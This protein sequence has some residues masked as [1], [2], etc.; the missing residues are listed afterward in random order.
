MAAGRSGDGSLT[1]DADAPADDRLRLVNSALFLVVVVLVSLCAVGAVL[2]WQTQQERSEARDQ[3]ERYGEVLAAASAQAEA[4]VNIDYRSAE[5]SYAAV[6][7]G[8][9]GDFK[10]QYDTSRESVTQVLADNESVM[11]GDV[12]WAGVSTLDRDSATVLVATSGTV[13]NTETKNEPVAR[14]FR[15]QLE[16]ERVGDR[17]LTADLV[18]VG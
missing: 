1:G 7:E 5:E 14:N 17:W 11:T 18:F 8:A 4:F 10:E 15:L 2:V 6:A 9:T 13:S 12:L 16:M 3:Q